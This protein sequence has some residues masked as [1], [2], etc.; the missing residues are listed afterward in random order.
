MW[1]GPVALWLHE[2]QAAMG[3]DLR[4]PRRRT[5]TIR[6]PKREFWCEVIAETVII[7]LRR[8]AGS[9][10][11]GSANGFLVRCNQLECQYVDQNRPPCPLHVGLFD[12]DAPHTK[13]PAA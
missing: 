5:R 6:Q 2:W 13:N 11:P 1:D 7:A 8:P 12:V 10:E 4:R 9:R 3:R